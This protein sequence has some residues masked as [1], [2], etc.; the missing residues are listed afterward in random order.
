VTTGRRPFWFDPATRTTTGRAV[1]D[2]DIACLEVRG[3]VPE[4]GR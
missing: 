1:E 2:A 3:W 4:E